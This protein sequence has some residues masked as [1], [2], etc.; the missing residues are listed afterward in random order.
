MYEFLKG[1][2]PDPG[3]FIPLRTHQRRKKKRKKER[4]IG[5]GK[6]RGKKKEGIGKK[7]RRRERRKEKGGKRGKK[8]I[9]DSNLLR[10]IKDNLCLEKCIWRPFHKLADNYDSRS[11]AKLTHCHCSLSVEG[12]SEL[13]GVQYAASFSQEG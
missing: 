9:L 11:W 12:G 2:S 4:W 7:E 3:I 8:G 5:E 10:K 13:L 1:R 6:K